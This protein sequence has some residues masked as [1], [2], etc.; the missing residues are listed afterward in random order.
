MNYTTTLAQIGERDHAEARDALSERLLRSTAG[1]FDIF[2]IYMGHVLGFYRQLDGSAYM[3]STELAR[4]AG[5]HERYTREWLEQQ[6]VAGIVEV[7][8]E[9]AEAL[10]RRFRLPSGNREVLVE[11]ESLNYLAPLTQIAVGAVYPIHA[12]LEAYRTGGGVPYGAYGADMRAGQAGMNRNLF[13]YELGQKYLRAIPDLHRRLLDDP[14]AR[15]ADIGCGAGWSSIG[16]CLA[17][18]KVQVDGFDLDAPSV[19]E[20]WANAHAYGLGDR[21]TFH[22]RDAGSESLNGRY[23]LV[24]AFECIH[25]LGNPVAALRT[26]RRLA[27]DKG[28]VIVMDERVGDTFTAK[29]NE[30]EWMMYGWSVL[31]CLP[32]GMADSRPS[33]GTGTVMRTD[34]LRGYAQEAGFR[35]VKVLP[36]EN[37]FFRF[38]RLQ[39]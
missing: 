35:E 2:T 28:I 5:T 38:Y 24:T 29:G 10:S 33:V 27:G 17:Y 25:D 6:T 9:T 8:D 7:E 13:L 1:L 18:P 30:V 36:I 15:V 11:R 23:D 32:V 4:V 12:V 37:F 22:A 20:A 31:H 19:E 34:T 14:P 3:T 16:M 26:M 21:L 39:G